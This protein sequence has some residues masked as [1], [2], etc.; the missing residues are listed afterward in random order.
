MHRSQR[1]IIRHGAP[2]AALFLCFSSPARAITIDLGLSISQPVVEA[3]EAD[4]NN[5]LAESAT[6]SSLWPSISLQ[7]RERYIGESNW[8]YSVSAMAWYY[9]VDQQKDGD[10]FVDYGTSVKG[11]YAYVTPTIYY[12]FGD[13]YVMKSQDRWNWSVGLGLGIGYLVA[14]GNV[15]TNYSSTKTTESF[16]VDN[17]AVSSGIFIEAVRNRWFVRFSSYGPESNT[18][19]SRLKIRLSDNTITIG[20]RF[21]LREIFQ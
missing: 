3:R 19:N 1:S 6:P 14:D 7:S 4:S 20:K 17:G 5:K 21:E 15:Y 18:S 9:D 8:G 13:K 11:Y 12:R 16:H 10:N 2:L